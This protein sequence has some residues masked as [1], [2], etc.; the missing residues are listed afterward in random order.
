MDRH[1]WPLASHPLVPQNRN[2]QLPNQ[3]LK[4]WEKTFPVTFRNQD[5]I[6]L[7]LLHFHLH[8]T[9]F[10][11]EKNLFWYF[12]DN[13]FQHLGVLTGISLSQLFSHVLQ[14]IV[15][16]FFY[17]FS[18]NH[19]P[20]PLI[21][22]AH[23]LNS[24]LIEVTWELCPSTVIIAYSLSYAEDVCHP[25]IAV[26]SVVCKSW[27]YLCFN[28]ELLGLKKSSI[29]RSTSALRE[30]NARINFPFMLSFTFIAYFEL[31]IMFVSLSIQLTV[32]YSAWLISLFEKR[33]WAHA[34]MLSWAYCRSFWK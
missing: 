14:L 33:I 32:V 10:E 4:L 18:A 17:L 23:F 3:A 24:Y 6:H 19:P 25:S 34:I 8:S 11:S 29:L 26:H 15:T 28:R 7:V 12:R 31:P 21:T 20:A 9:R 13:S 27:H 30:I 1:Y 2:Q 16:H 5:F 22:D